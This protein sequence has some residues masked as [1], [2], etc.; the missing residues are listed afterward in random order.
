MEATVVSASP[1]GLTTVTDALS[2]KA[3]KPSPGLESVNDLASDP[4]SPDAA[5][6]GLVLPA[7]GDLRA[8]RLVDDD[9][10]LAPGTTADD[11]GLDGDSRVAIY[12][13][14]N[15]HWRKD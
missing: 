7:P 10:A 15:C 9:H 1:E 8:G 13:S 5:H 4:L 3:S 12:A 6:I 2:A 14:V 11:E